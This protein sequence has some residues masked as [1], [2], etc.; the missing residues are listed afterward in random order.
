MLQSPFADLERARG[1]VLRDYGGLTLVETYSD[2]LTESADVRATAGIFDRSYRTALRFT[3]PDR[4]TFL[5]N[6]LSNDIAAL[7]S[8][9]GCYATL[10]TR[11][12]K[13]VADANV[14][15]MEHSVRL[16]LDV[17]VKDRARAHLEKFLVAD[18]V[19]I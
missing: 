5:H 15:C 10:L 16:D 3:G 19:E 6:L 11:E 14:F 17:R 7:R 9:T 4:V 2:P 12:S 18:D 1:A 13:V 8:G